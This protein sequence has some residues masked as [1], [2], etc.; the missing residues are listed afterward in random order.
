MMMRAEI[1]VIQ[2]NPT[3]SALI[4][5]PALCSTGTL[6]HKISIRMLDTL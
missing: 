6:S 3:V 2:T 5:V 1:T 4:Y